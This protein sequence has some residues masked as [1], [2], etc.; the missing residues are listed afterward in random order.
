LIISDIE[1][2]YSSELSFKWFLYNKESSFE[3]GMD[4][5]CDYIQ[6]NS[7]FQCNAISSL[8]STSTL[9]GISAQQTVSMNISQICGCDFSKSDI[10]CLNGTMNQG[11]CC[12]LNLTDCFTP[13][14]KPCE[15]YPV[16]M[17]ENKTTSVRGKYQ[18]PNP[19]LIIR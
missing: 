15:L 4:P 7:T 9:T 19:F 13:C 18:S 8:M 11:K 12:T 16:V 5:P 17:I 6:S 10:L 14:L 3:W 1:D 2:I